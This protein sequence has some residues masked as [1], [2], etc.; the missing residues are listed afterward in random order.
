MTIIKSKKDT[1]P[2]YKRQLWVRMWNSRTLDGNAEW[3]IHYE[4][5]YEASSKIT[6]KITI[7]LLFLAGETQE[8]K[9][10]PNSNDFQ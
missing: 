2:K 3:C 8:I 1:P 4:K 6:D 9:K 7:W 10:S 5:P